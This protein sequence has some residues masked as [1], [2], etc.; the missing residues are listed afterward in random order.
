[1]TQLENLM[2]LAKETNQTQVTVLPSMFGSWYCSDKVD[3]GVTWTATS[4]KNGAV[5][6]TYTS[7][8][9]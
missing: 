7:N 4:F 1:M 8:K 2:R 3:K 6:L 5:E 9:Y